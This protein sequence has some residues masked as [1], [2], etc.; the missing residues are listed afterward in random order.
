MCD[1]VM[2]GIYE[3]AMGQLAARYLQTLRGGDLVTAMESEALGLVAEIKEI[4]DDESLEDPQCF[5]KV[6]AIVDAFQAR[7]LGTSRHDD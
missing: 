1:E 3:I 2:K 4:L 7:G 5:R 6:D